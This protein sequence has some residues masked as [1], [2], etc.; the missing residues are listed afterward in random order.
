MEKISKNHSKDKEDKYDK[1][2]DTAWIKLFDYYDLSD[3]FWTENLM[4]MTAT[5]HKKYLQ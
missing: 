1:D 5:I 2:E 4:K 3:Y